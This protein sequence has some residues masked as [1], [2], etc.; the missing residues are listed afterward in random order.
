MFHSSK[1]SNSSGSSSVYVE[2][3][4]CVCDGRDGC[5]DVFGGYRGCIRGRPTG[6]RG[7]IAA[8]FVVSVRSSAYRKKK[9]FI[10]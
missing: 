4:G 1:S 9:Q 2:R 7:F 6:L 5:E 3:R 8:P 10:R